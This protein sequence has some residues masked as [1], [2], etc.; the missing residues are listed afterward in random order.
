MHHLNIGT[1]LSK[2]FFKEIRKYEG[3]NIRENCEIKIVELVN[4]TDGLNYFLRFLHDGADADPVLLPHFG[5][6]AFPY[7]AVP[8][9]L[10]VYDILQSFQSLSAADFFPGAGPIPLNN[11]PALV[12]GGFQYHHAKIAC[13]AVME[14]IQQ[15]GRINA[16]FQGLNAV[17]SGQ[18]ICDLSLT[19]ANC[20]V[21][22]RLRKF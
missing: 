1:K 17:P 4:S 8:V 6:L 13:H 5:P 18:V 22:V 21:V 7:V 10:E 3:V 15:P 16:P 9:Q 14:E 2:T 20:I 19:F 11:A 12:M